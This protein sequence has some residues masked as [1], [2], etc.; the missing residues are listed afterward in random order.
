MYIIKLHPLVPSNNVIKIYRIE[1][2]SKNLNLNE[3]KKSK[4]TIT[5]IFHKR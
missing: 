2:K 3:Q 5:N 4:T 1:K